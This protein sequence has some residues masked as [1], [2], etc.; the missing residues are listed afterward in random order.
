[1]FKPELITLIHNAAVIQRWNDHIRPGTGFV[2]MDKQAHKTF[3][4]FVLAKCHEDAG[5]EVD[6]VK[7]I[8][9][10]IFEFLHRVIL[11]DIKPPIYHKLKKEMGD[12]ID[13]YVECE[14]KDYLEGIKDFPDKMH[15]YFTDLTYSATERDIIR[16]AHYLATKWEFDIIYPLNIGMYNIEKTK[17]EVNES[18]AK[19]NWFD[20]KRVFYQNPKL[21]D[22][23][24]LIGQLR[25]QQ[26]WTA[27]ARIPQTSVMAHTFVVAVLSYFCTVETGGCNQRIEN[28]F[29]GA[30]FHDLP[31]V[32]TRDII[33][34]VKRGV[35][36]LDEI[37]KNIEDSQMKSVIY[38][39][40]PEKWVQQLEFFT[41]D[42]FSSKVVING[43]IKTVTSEEI[44]K[45][46]NE[47]IFNPIDGKIIRAC[48]HLSAYL[49]AYLSM[50]NGIEA[51]PLKR[52][53]VTLRDTY[54]DLK[55]AGI[56]FGAYFEYFFEEAYNK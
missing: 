8:D 49:E 13:E 52:A 41:N 35:E 51:E 32:L 3:Y 16:F 25:F 12:K 27:T 44:S 40:I 21:T 50:K 11:T 54:K 39:L 4:A 34:P 36:G 6:Y 47:K 46:Y 31:E 37:I 17:A 43:E 5:G 38:P 9:G 33:S 2:E 10:I 48:D 42:E 7:L 30:L 22:F 55:V 1:M 14:L 24:N 56:D 20:G 29:F 23:L 15:K 18:L 28:N 26:R 45:N 53:L 19:C